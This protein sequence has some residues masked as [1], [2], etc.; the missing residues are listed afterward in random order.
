MFQLPAPVLPVRPPPTG[1]LR[2]VRV[3]SEYNLHRSGFSLPATLI[4]RVRDLSVSIRHNT[5][6]I[7]PMQHH[8]VPEYQVHSTEILLY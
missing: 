4:Q 8:Y 6:G 1:L 7:S 5:D 3:G 2:A